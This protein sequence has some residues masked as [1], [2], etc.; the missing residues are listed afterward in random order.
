MNFL[1]RSMRDASK[2]CNTETT[3]GEACPPVMS[4][5]P[6]CIHN[7]RHYRLRY[8]QWSSGV[9]RRRSPQTMLPMDD[10]TLPVATMLMFVTRMIREIEC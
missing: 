1:S 4:T 5:M 2:W 6:R 7:L 8:R 3:A 10:E 9:Q